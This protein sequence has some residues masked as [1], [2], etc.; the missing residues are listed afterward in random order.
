MTE[1]E[2]EW[3]LRDLEQYATELG[4]LKE[5]NKTEQSQLKQK[6]IDMYEIKIHNLKYKIKK[7]FEII[8]NNN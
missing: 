5:I 8:K 3:Y 4:K 6:T 7:Q 2:L 1:K